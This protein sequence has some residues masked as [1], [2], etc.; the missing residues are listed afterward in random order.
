LAGLGLDFGCA[1]L[2][3][4][5][6]NTRIWL[7][8]FRYT[9]GMAEESLAA[10]CIQCR[11]CEPKCTQHSA[12]SEWMPVVHAVLGEDKTYGEVTT[13]TSPPKGAT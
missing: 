6:D 2:P 9:Q 4:T 10:E 3:Q 5:G 8:R 12:I 7:S 11:E 1:R 13:P